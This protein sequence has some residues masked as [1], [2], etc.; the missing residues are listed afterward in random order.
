MI[1]LEYYHYAVSSDTAGR[2]NTRDHSDTPGAP[3]TWQA[4]PRALG[5]QRQTRARHNSY[6]CGTRL[7]RS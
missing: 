7:V 6:P 2:I 5:R 3:T 4:L 1:S